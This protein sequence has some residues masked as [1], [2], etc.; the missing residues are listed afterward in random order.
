M[1]FCTISVPIPSCSNPIAPLITSALTAA[2]TAG[3]AITPYVI[4][5]SGSNPI[6]YTTGTLPSGLTF[7]SS[8]HTIS[9][10]VAA[11][12]VYNIVL[13]ADNS[14]GTDTKTLVLTIGAA[15]APPHITSPLTASG[16]AASPFSYTITAS[17][18][19]TQ[20]CPMTFTTSALPAGL[21]LQGGNVIG[22]SP[23]TPNTYDITLTAHNCNSPDDVKHL[24]LT[25]APAGVVPVIS[26]PL[27]ASGT[28]GTVFTPYTLTTSAGTAPITL[29]ATNLPAGLSYDAGTHQ[30]TG[31][32]TSP[33]QTD[34]TLTA[35]NAYGTDVK[36]LIITIAQAPGTPPV[37]QPPL[38]LQ[39][40]NHRF[41]I[42]PAT[43]SRR[44]LSP[45]SGNGIIPAGQQPQGILVELVRR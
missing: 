8:T 25:V 37:I 34:V 16:T 11:A 1:T 5:A 23:T 14:V 33:G 31:T 29:N 26:S 44:Q 43:F 22:G 20:A 15:G 21:T 18:D 13:T 4:T 24:I 42:I 32:P 12:G 40:K 9:G 7:N 30:I 3:L 38:T 35:S 6:T 45:Y 2:G 27:T 36:H 17:G 41:G 19:N 39:A 28:A 10:T